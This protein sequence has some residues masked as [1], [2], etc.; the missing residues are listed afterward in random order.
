VNGAIAQGKLR[1]L[2]VAAPQRLPT[3]PD[4]PTF[5]ELGHPDANLNSVFGVFAPSRTPREV[6]AKLNAEINKLLADKDVQ[7]RLAKL[8]NVVSPTSID[9]FT[10]RVQREYDANA[11]VVREAG[12][13]AD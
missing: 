8:D 5:T 9:A 10:M 7:E 1:V 6:L 11:A 3:M 2:A 12:I 4:V 13:K